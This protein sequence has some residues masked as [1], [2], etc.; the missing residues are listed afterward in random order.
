MSREELTG[1][2]LVVRENATVEQA[3]TA[4]AVLV[5]KRIRRMFWFDMPI[6]ELH[7]TVR[8]PFILAI[9][10]YRGKSKSELRRMVPRSVRKY[11]EV[12]VRDMNWA[13]LAV[14][15]YLK[16]RAADEFGPLTWDAKEITPPRLNRH[17]VEQIVVPDDFNLVP[18]E[19]STPGISTSEAK[20]VVERF[21]IPYRRVPERTVQYVR[22]ITRDRPRFFDTTFDTIDDNGSNW[23][24]FISQV[25]F[26]DSNRDSM[27]RD[28]RERGVQAINGYMVTSLNTTELR[29][30]AFVLRMRSPYAHTAFRDAFVRDAMHAFGLRNLS[31]EDYAEVMDNA[32]QDFEV[33]EEIR[34]RAVMIAH[35]HN[36]NRLDRIRRHPRAWI[37]FVAAI[38]WEDLSTSALAKKLVRHRYLAVKGNMP[39]EC[40][41]F[42]LALALTIIRIRNRDMDIRFDRIVQRLLRGHR[43]PLRLRSLRGISAP[44]E[45]GHDEAK[46]YRSESAGKLVRSTSAV[47]SECSNDTNPITLEPFT[48]D[49]LKHGIVTIKLPG[50]SKGECYAR[51]DLLSL[52]NGYLQERHF[53]VY[54]WRSA[55][56]DSIHL[57]QPLFKVPL[58]NV[59]ITR[60][61][62]EAAAAHRR[63]RLVS[64]GKRFIGSDHHFVSGVYGQEQTVYTVNKRSS[65]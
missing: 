10:Y 58:S 33:P 43:G 52:W 59:W 26:A 6:F 12:W 64:M 21:A 19:M 37:F 29:F 65:P 40:T 18:S 1:A 44:V 63:I 27:V 23:V 9:C 50:A 47:D 49:E 22:N 30:C 28:T 62:A 36:S 54:L 8:S 7:D 61:A 3:A 16:M 41:W 17:D 42:D 20:A 45:I 46:F 48:A 11:G 25:T 35:H 53:I 60:D 15:N 31:H 13:E 34:D 24:Y 38:L 57:G 56:P 39:G 55:N 5:R 2:C 51:D 4:D 14:Y 32:V